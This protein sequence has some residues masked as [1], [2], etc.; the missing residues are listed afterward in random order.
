[1]CGIFCTVSLNSKINFWKMYN[2]LNLTMKNRGP[3]AHNEILLNHDSGFIFFAGFVLWQQ[4]EKLQ[5]Q[6]VAKNDFIILF[7]GDL[8]NIN[9]SLSMSDTTWLANRISECHTHEDLVSLVKVLEGP[10]CL[11]IYNKVNQMLYFAR[12]TL[13]RNSLIIERHQ[14]GLNLLSTS[15]H[16]SKEQLSSIELPPLGLYQIRV[17]DLSSCVLYPWQPINEYTGQLIRILDLTLNWQTKVKK[18]ISPSWL[19]S[20]ETQLCYDFYKYDYSDNFK[21]LYDNLIS[22]PQI[23]LALDNL[24]ILLCASVNARIKSKPPFCCVCLKSKPTECR[25][26]KICILFSGGIDCTILAFLSHKLLPI[27][28]PIELI[29]VAFERISGPSTF[30][31]AWSVPDRKTSLKSINELKRICPGRCWTLLEVNVTRSELTNILST[32]IKHLIYP[33]QKILDES[34]GCA[35][36]FASHSSS[37]TSR[38]AIIGSG[39][40]ELFGGYTRHRNSYT[41]CH[42]NEA[43]RQNA[44]KTELEFDWQRIPARNLARD[45]RVIADNGKTARAPFLEENFVA[46]VRS[47]EPYQK[48]C[49]AFPEGI[50]DKLLLRLY[51]YRLGL[52]DV[53]FLKKKAIQFGSRIANKKQNASQNSDILIF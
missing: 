24:D 33:L 31:Q 22:Q 48:C 4:G 29:N 2:S 12:D 1:M 30:E 10:F 11:I 15:R 50:G 26:A 13:G 41:R 43:V 7:N 14:S 3:D 19:L 9:K 20:H 16:Y 27:E 36:W 39:A 8:Y 17:N 32:H 6:P 42:G 38:V 23:K 46:F 45:D 44:V 28:E 5:K 40:D 18:I 51:G 52:T 21:T 34:L 49:F 35:F 25:H 47:L 37:S 53:A